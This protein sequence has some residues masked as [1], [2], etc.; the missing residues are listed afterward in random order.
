MSAMRQ[1][2]WPA[3]ALVLPNQTVARATITNYDLP[4]PRMSLLLDEVEKAVGQVS[5]LLGDPAPEV[6]LIPG[7]GE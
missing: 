7:F 1:L 6:R 4:E 3:L 2:F 5:G